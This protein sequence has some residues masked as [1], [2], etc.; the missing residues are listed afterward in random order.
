MS[1]T[2]AQALAMA[3][4]AR[5]TISE[6]ADNLFIANTDSCIL[7]AINLGQSRT[8][9]YTLHGVNIQSVFNYYV[10]LGYLVYFPDIQPNFF[11][12]PINLFGYQFE[13]YI[14]NI[15]PNQVARV[16]NPLRMTLDWSNGEP[17]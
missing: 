3:E 16:G 7:N 9:V 17:L 2:Q 11:V 12:N 13:Q 6:A 5:N 1:L 10:N 15:I 8:T 14:L 4:A